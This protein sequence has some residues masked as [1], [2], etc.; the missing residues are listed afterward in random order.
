MRFLGKFVRFLGNFI[1]V[2]LSVLLSIVMLFM[3]VA[4]PMVSGLSAFTRPETIMQ[5]VHEIDFANIIWEN[6]SGELSEE[7]RKSL[8]AIVQMTETNAFGELVELY[9]TDMTNALDG[10]EKPSVLTEEALR[11]IMNNNMDE[12]V[13]MVRQIGE[14]MGEDSSEYSDAE[15]EEQVR[16]LFDEV[17]EK[18]LEMALTA[19]DLRKLLLKL[20]DEFTTDSSTSNERPNSSSEFIEDS[21]DTPSYEF[22]ES[23]GDSDITYMPGDGT[24]T[25]IIVGPDGTIQSGDGEYF[26]TRDPE[27]GAITIVGGDGSAGSI[28]AVGGTMTFGKAVSLQNNAGRILLMGL[29][30]SGGDEKH[31]EVADSVLELV[32]MAKNGTLTLVFVGAIAILALLIC[33]LRWPRFKGLMWVAVMLLI[34]AVFVALAG[35]A[36]TVLPGMLTENVGTIDLKSAVKP[37]IQI[38]ANSM[39]V[40]AAIYAGI[41][42]V[43]IVLFVIL[44]KALRKAKATKAAEATRTE[45]IEQIADEAESA[46]V[47]VQ[48]EACPEMIAEA[49][50]GA[51]EEATEEATEEVASEEVAEPAAEEEAAEE[52]PAE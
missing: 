35:V 51:A 5:V 7:E 41:A 3:L 27:T 1:G 2:I 30:I 42:I 25:T 49:E 39:F 6:I 32:R 9:A 23:E 4:A 17:V 11:H 20:S 28:T 18:F 52:V 33:L 45:T 14:S 43:L 29:G 37:V 50:E 12:L 44:R 48:E 22:N 15:L 31:E 19:E 16:E 47:E 40:A 34:G 24:I 10:E 8:E 26:Y 21:Y 36:Y 38:I 13:D 46:A